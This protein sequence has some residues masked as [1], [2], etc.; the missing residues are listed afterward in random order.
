MDR[1]AQLIL[2]TLKD[3]RKE[4]LEQTEVLREIAGALHVMG[5]RLDRLS[6]PP[7]PRAGSPNEPAGPRPARLATIG[8][9]GRVNPNT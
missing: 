9:G 6:T 2:Q 3:T 8:Q 7:P 4:Q 1:N 5:E